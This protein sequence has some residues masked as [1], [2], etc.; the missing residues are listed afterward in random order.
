MNVSRLTEYAAF[1]GIDWADRKHASC[2]HVAG[3]D[4]RAFSVRPHR[5][6][7][8][9]PWAQVLRQRFEGRPIAVCLELRKGPLIYALPP[10]DFLVLVAVHPTT[11]AT[12]RQ[13]FCLS[14][15]QGD[16]TE[17]ELALERL[18]THRDTL[19]ALPPHSAAMRAVPRRVEQRRSLV[20]DTGRLT[21]RLTAALKPS[22]PQVLEWFQDKDTRVCCDVRTRWPTRKQAQR[23][24][25]AR[26]TAFFQEHHGRSP[27]L[28]EPRIH[29]IR[30][31]TALTT[32][33][34]VIRP[35]QWLVDVPVQQRRGV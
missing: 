24:R 34:G 22:C 9:A 6:E 25:N 5:P 21:H 3:C 28:V 1:A 4:Q 30:R 31:A 10:D 32:D 13:A 18:M 19:T 7:R 35:N 2:R 17:A 20:A 14:S 15:A 16:P 8:M 12:Y 26:L 33:S 11:L 27:H 23:A 29:A